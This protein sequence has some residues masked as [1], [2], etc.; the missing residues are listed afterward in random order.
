MDNNDV[1]HVIYHKG[2]NTHSIS[3]GLLDLKPDLQIWG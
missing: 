3:Y 2:H 1:I